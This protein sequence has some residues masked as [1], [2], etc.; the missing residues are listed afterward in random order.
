MVRIQN[1]SLMCRH[2]AEHLLWLLHTSKTQGTLNVTHA[3]LYGGKDYIEMQVQVL[4]VLEAYNLFN[5][6][7]TRTFPCLCDSLSG[8]SRL[9]L[10]CAADRWKIMVQSF[11]PLGWRSSVVKEVDLVLGCMDD[12]SV[13]LLDWT[14]SSLTF[15]RKKTKQRNALKA[16]N[17]QRNKLWRIH[18][19]IVNIDASSLIQHFA[20]FLLLFFKFIDVAVSNSHASEDKTEEQQDD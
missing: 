7:Q 4:Y 9:L 5:L 15:K 12:Y 14:W 10:I 18:Y 17:L 19:E 1:T 2:T 11:S 3:Y 20:A 6:K 16:L 13:N 8:V